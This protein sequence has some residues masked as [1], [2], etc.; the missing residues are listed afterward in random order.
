MRVEEKMTSRV[1]YTGTGAEE[2]VHIA[3][4]FLNT[5]RVP[6][7]KTNTVNVKKIIKVD[8]KNILT[9]PVTLTT[10]IKLKQ[11]T[12]YIKP[13]SQTSNWGQPKFDIRGNF[14]LG[15]ILNSDQLKFDGRFL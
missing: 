14:K 12:Y 5:S 4:S 1:P 9:L 15:S 3:S 10:N 8:L 2:S 11:L 13:I 7:G 6:G